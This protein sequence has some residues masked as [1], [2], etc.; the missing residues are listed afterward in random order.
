MA[1]RLPTVIPYALPAEPLTYP[2]LAAR[3]ASALPDKPVVLVAESFSGPLGDRPGRTATRKRGRVR[4][5]L[6]LRTSLPGAA[7]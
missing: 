2:E 3:V 4:E 6:R 1:P 7:K 5:Q